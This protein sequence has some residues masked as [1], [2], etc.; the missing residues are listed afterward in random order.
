MFTGRTRGRQNNDCIIQMDVSHSD[1]PPKYGL[2]NHVSPDC[3]AT[4]R[5]THNILKPMYGAS[6]GF[7]YLMDRVDRSVGPMG[8]GSAYTGEFWTADLDMRHLDPG[9]AHKNKE[10]DNL[11]VTFVETGNYTLRVD[12]WIDGRFRETLSFAQTVDTNYCGAYVLGQSICGGQDEKTIWQRMHGQ[13]RR[14]MLRCYNSGNNQNFKVSML[15]IGFRP[16]GE[17]ATKL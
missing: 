12:V 1:Q 16:S 17:Q 4:R 10:W 3:L 7:I 8:S 13:G 15:T 5:D 6:D 9:L 2:W 14:V 11:G